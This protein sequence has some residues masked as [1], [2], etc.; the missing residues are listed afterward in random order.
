MHIDMLIGCSKGNRLEVDFYLYIGPIYQIP[1]RYLNV[2]MS[3]LKIKQRSMNMKLF[4][5]NFNNKILSLKYYLNLSAKF[6]IKI[7]F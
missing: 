7:Y 1:R 3:L 4:Y 2:F 5:S 6:K